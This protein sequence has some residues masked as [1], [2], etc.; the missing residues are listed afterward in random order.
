MAAPDRLADLEDV[1]FGE[2]LAERTRGGPYTVLG[3]TGGGRYM[4]VVLAPLGEGLWR[5]VSARDMNDAERRRY[6]RR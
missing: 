5:V 1:C 6:R 2:H 3:Q 4:A